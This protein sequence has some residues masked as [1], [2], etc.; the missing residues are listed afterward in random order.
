MFNPNSRKNLKGELYRNRAVLDTFEPG[1]TLKPFVVAAALDGGYVSEDIQ[2]ETHGFFRVGRN[3][4]RDVHNYGTLDLLHVLKKSSNVAVSKLALSMPAEYFCGVYSQLGFGMLSQVGFPGEASGFLP[5]Y[6]GLNEFERATLAYG[7]GVS[8]SVLQLARAYT[9]LA[10][11][12]VLHSVSLLRRDK[13]DDARQV[14]TPRTAKLVREM[15]E[16]VVKKDGTAYR[17][18]VDGYRVGGKT[19]TVKKAIAG[20]YAEKD[21]LAV[22]VGLAPVSN[23]RFV[24]AVMVDEPSA[25]KYYGGL[26]A[27][28]VFAE[29]M[30]GALRLY[31]VAPDNEDTM[32]VLLTSAK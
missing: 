3:V 1:S 23:P 5:E 7:Y 29:V 2:I 22:F 25:G 26:V 31:G 8:V 13:D 11:D 20:G 15:L 4:V 21:Y 10:D 18:R 16:H 6:Q 19:G 14:F 30:A 27:A 12:G 24:I 17:A 9:A 32:P 28:P